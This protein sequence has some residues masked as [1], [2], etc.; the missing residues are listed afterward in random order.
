MQN[1]ITHHTHHASH[2]LAR[3]DLHRT[4]S[5]SG[6]LSYPGS[7][8]TLLSH[9][10]PTALR[11]AGIMFPLPSLRSAPSSRQVLF[12]S[13]CCNLTWSCGTCGLHT[14][15]ETMTRAKH[16]PA[17]SPTLPTVRMQ[18]RQENMKCHGCSARGLGLSLAEVGAPTLENLEDHLRVA[19]DAPPSSVCCS[20][21]SERLRTTSKHVR[22][23]V[24]SY[25]HCVRMHTRGCPFSRRPPRE[26]IDGRGCFG[27]LRSKEAYVRTYTNM[28]ATWIWA[29]KFQYPGPGRDEV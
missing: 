25:A 27:I 17:V 24:R 9:G 22:A 4:F 1:E 2:G 11:A 10:G 7:G 18:H 12:S 28:F 29:S 13:T 8:T 16:A 26:Q 6:S 19:V 3:H 20:S 15:W 21:R 5:T 23:Y 14:G